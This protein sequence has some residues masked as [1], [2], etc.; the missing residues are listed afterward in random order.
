M[1]NDNGGTMTWNF[2]ADT[3]TSPTTYPSKIDFHQS[4]TTGYGGYFWYT[5]TLPSASANP[6]GAQPPQPNN[7]DLEVTGTWAPP[8][9]MTGWTRIMAS[10][11]AE[12]AWDPQAN[13]QI[14][15][16]NGTTE[17]RV[18]NQAYQT[19]KWVSLGFF[20]LSKG[21]SVSLSNITYQGLGDDIAWGAV[22]FIPAKAP[23]TDY[24]A[25]GDSYSSAEGLNPYTPNS[26]YTYS[27]MMNDC[28]RSATQGFP[29][30]V[31]M[32]G[33]STSIEQQAATPSSDVQFSSIACS[34]ALTPSITENAI[35]SGGNAAQNI[36]L[37]WDNAG[38][39]QWTSNYEFN[40]GPSIY[41]AVT[42]TT[43]S[44][45]SVELPQADQGWLS[46]TTSLVTI[47]QGG[48]DARFASVMT[49]CDETDATISTNGNGCSA[50]TY[51]LTN[52][53]S[54]VLD[55]DPLDGFEPWLLTGCPPPGQGSCAESA[56][57]W[58]VQQVY[59][60]IAA[61][62]PNAAII[63][64]EYPQLFPGGTNPTSPCAPDAAI[65]IP[66]ADEAMLN[67]F[68]LH[69]ARSLLVE[70]VHQRRG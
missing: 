53:L 2:G 64:V 11:P 29:D 3:A 21:A 8:S 42:Q 7:A 68:G 65:S 19:D 69:R 66:P 30:L 51:Y 35:D 12:G 49:G 57:Q 34:N 10:I 36:W 59:S 58:H 56:I 54:G 63:V 48:D 50:S 14:K 43:T 1:W 13:Y 4:G 39:T 40:G 9:T 55:P 44:P 15:L 32:P 33:Q 20:N 17:Y 52:T 41:N 70:S 27:G 47:T 16:G 31:K 46:P 18:L 26:D 23:T 37:G 28:H 62:A 6:G 61:A 67:Q 24:V 45:T 25:M 60:A 38:H 22:A 5:H